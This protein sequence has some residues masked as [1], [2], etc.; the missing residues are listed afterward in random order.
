MLKRTSAWTFGAWLTCSLLLAGCAKMQYEDGARRSMA[1]G[2]AMPAAGVSMDSE[3]SYGATMTAEAPAPPPGVPAPQGAGAPGQE[4]APQAYAKSGLSVDRWFSPAV[5]AADTAPAEEYLI[6]NGDLLVLVQNYADAEKQAGQIAERYGGVLT[7]SHMEKNYDGTRTGYVTLR[8]PG[9][10]FLAAWGELAKLGEVQDQN[11]STQDVS[12]EYV[13][14]V[15]QMKNLLDEQQTLQGM[16]SDA[17][18]VQRT[19]GLGEAYKVL[20]DTQARLSDVT[21]ELRGVEDRIAQLADSITRSTIKLNITEKQA[22]QAAEFTWGFGDT[23][24]SAWKSVVLGYKRA[25]NN[26]IFL[27]ITA[28]LWVPWVAVLGVLFWLLY[29]RRGKAKPGPAAPAPT[30]S[31]SA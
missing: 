6:R 14:A 26:A 22:Y 28:P 15:S 29:R 16:L 3:R 30:S 1:P 7:D 24:K 8:V 10:S 27:I 12:Q 19:R 4:F 2:T 9:K 13:S 25:V 20:L 11:V 23:S 17:R 5:Y 21:G 18:E 31:D